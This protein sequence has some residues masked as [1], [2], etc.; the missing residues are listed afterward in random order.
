MII[1]ENIEFTEIKIRLSLFLSKIHSNIN[2]IIQ[3]K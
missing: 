3:E 2:Q 1:P